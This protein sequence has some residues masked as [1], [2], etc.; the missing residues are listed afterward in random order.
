MKQL[1]T[2]IMGF[3]AGVVTMHTQGQESVRIAISKGTSTDSYLAYG[4]W[5]KKLDQVVEWIDLASQ[6]SDSVETVLL[7][8]DGLL[9]SGG[10]DVFPGRF[11]R[12]AEASL[13]E[14]IDYERDTLEFSLI[15][16]ASEHNMPVLGICRGLQ[17]LNVAYG[18]SLILDIPTEHPSDVRHRCEDKNNCFHGIRLS[19]ETLLRKVAGI[20][21][22]VSNS[23]HHQAIRDIAPAFMATAF[24]PDGII[25]A[26]EWQEAGDKPFLLAVQ[27]HPEK[28][29][30]N[31]P[32][33]GNIGMSF[34][35]AVKKFHRF[36]SYE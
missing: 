21:E 19:D 25:E 33:S 9:L 14:E 34:I 6:P 5:L 10:P 35:A 8:C 22:G 30:I 13:C 20:P 12:E 18:G 36:K 1:L 17:I 26:I 7:Q 4:S 3:I 16:L 15:Q 2:I 31:N 32:L 27:W 29:D 28:M 11:G 23:S 24:A